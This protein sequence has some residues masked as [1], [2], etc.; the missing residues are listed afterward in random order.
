MQQ[1]TRKPALYW[2]GTIPAGCDC[3]GIGIHSEFVDGATIHGP[4]AN[5]HPTCHLRIGRGIGPGLGQR[6]RKQDDG[7]W[8]KVEG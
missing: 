6:Y 4:W 2:H 8:M 3:C 1:E 7:R 5:L